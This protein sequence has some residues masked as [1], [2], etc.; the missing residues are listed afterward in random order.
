MFGP[1]WVPAWTAVSAIAAAIAVIVATAYTAITYRV[2]VSQDD[3]KVIV[4]VRH[5]PERPTL[6]T[7]V[8]ENIGRSIAEDVKFR[9]SRPIPS[10][11]YG[12][13]AP[14]DDVSQQMVNGPLIKGIPALGPGDRRVLNWGQYGGLSSAL[15]NEP[16][17]VEIDYRHGRRRLHGVTYL[18]VESYAATDVSEPPNVTVAKSV[19]KIPAALDRISSQLREFGSSLNSH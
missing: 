2:L 6:L 3:P 13:Q 9:S 1:E 4:F 5:D 16:I 12:I 10:K 7:I 11:A 19:Q 14:S 15:A 17:R 8:I 18:D